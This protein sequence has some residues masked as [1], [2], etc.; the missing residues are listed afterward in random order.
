MAYAD[1]Y[2][3]IARY[4]VVETLGGA[5]E[6]NSSWIHYAEKAVE[7]KLAKGFTIPFAGSHPTIVDLVLDEAYRRILLTRE[8][9]Q[10]QALSDEIEKKVGLLLEGTE[11]IA[12]GSG[13]A[14]FADTDG[15]Y[16]TNQAYK[17]TF[18]MRDARYQRIDPDRLDDEDNAD[19]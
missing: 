12:T 19:D 4:R 5:K 14:I 16:H 13:T 18:D 15:I 3:L 2:A 11:T 10:A 7:A 17:P 9:A 6:V 1:Y 8:P